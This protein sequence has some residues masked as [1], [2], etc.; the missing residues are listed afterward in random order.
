VLG[1]L[2][3]SLLQYAVDCWPWSRATDTSELETPEQKSIEQMTARQQEFVARLVDLIMHEG[4]AVDLGTFDDHSELHY[5]G[6]DYLLGKLLAD[7]QEL[8][9]ELQSALSA[10]DSDVEARTLVAEILASEHENVA[11]L[12]DLSRSASATVVA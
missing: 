12:G 11:R 8:V 10:L 9:G 4:G 3:R 5:V 1:R 6:V 2:N 7:E